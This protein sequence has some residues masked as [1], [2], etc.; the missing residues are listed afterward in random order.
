MLQTFL[1]TK[2]DTEMFDASA[3]QGMLHDIVR[4]TEQRG[5]FLL[6]K[7]MQGN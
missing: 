2:E 5:H 7:L 4:V 6:D 3:Q 1:S